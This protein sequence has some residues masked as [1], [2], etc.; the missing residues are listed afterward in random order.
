MI[1]TIV[2]SLI[3]ITIGSF[4]IVDGCKTEII[5]LGRCEE[6]GLI[7]NLTVDHHTCQKEDL[8]YRSYQTIVSYPCFSLWMTIEFNGKSITMRVIDYSEFDFKQYE[9]YRVGG[10]RRIYVDKGTGDWVLDPTDNDKDRVDLGIAM[11]GTGSIPILILSA[12]GVAKVIRDFRDALSTIDL[13]GAKKVK[14]NDSEM[15]NSA[16]DTS[17]IVIE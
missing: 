9:N 17:V 6:K 10:T 1:M 5:C 8:N 12:I 13:K 7:T 3:L 16:T 4:A 15:S 14:E 2:A 11:I